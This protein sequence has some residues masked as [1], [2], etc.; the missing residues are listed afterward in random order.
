MNENEN[1]NYEKTHEK[2]AEKP[3]SKD[4]LKQEILIIRSEFK[5]KSSEYKNIQENILKSKEILSNLLSE[6]T[7]KKNL[8]LE[9]EKENEALLLKISKIRKN[10]LLSINKTINKKFYNHLKGILGDKKKERLLFHFFNFIFNLYNICKNHHFQNKEKNNFVNLG[11]DNDENHDIINLLRILKDENELKNLILYTTEIIKN[12]NTEEPNIYNK[13]KEMY[14]NLYNKIKNEEKPY[15]IDLL[16][17]Y[18]NN[19]FTIINYEKQVEDIKM[20]LNNL[21]NEKNA[22]FVKI[23]NLELLI[24]GYNVNKKIISNYI[25]I[26]DA[27]L[28]KINNSEKKTEENIDKLMKDIE[29]FKK[30]KIN[31]DNLNNNLELTKALPLGNDNTFYDKSSKKNDFKDNS[32]QFDYIT[33]SNEDCNKIEKI[34]LDEVKF[35]KEKNQNNFFEVGKENV[36]Y[37]KINKSFNINKREEKTRNL[38]INLKKS[39]NKTGNNIKCFNYKTINNNVSLNKK[40]I[41]NITTNDIKFKTNQKTFLEKD[42]FNKV[43]NNKTNN[44]NK[45]NWNKAHL[46]KKLKSQKIIKTKI[47]KENS[48]SIKENKSFLSLSNF[49]FSK[50]EKD[51]YIKPNNKNK[52]K[53][54][55]T[56]NTL[57]NKT[58]INTK[59]NG[60]KKIFH[61]KNVKKRNFSGNNIEKELFKNQTFLAK[62]EL[63]IE[64]NNIE[65]NINRQEIEEKNKQREQND[66]IENTKPNKEN[67]FIENNLDI[68]ELKD[69]I[70]DEMGSKKINNGNYLI[71]SNTNN[72]INK[73]GIQQNIVWSENLY[74]KINM[75]NSPNDIQLNIDK[76]IE[77]FTC[78]A[79]CT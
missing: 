17:D 3:N 58:Q 9:K 22:K 42:I 11:L 71:I 48:K 13:V 57:I 47:N 70:C 61:K 52:N 78:C 5:N 51:S 19:N 28:L 21:T 33:N 40:N 27:F 1:K 20:T 69:S 77:S 6:Y 43:K 49:I 29:N 54:N 55:I 24:K 31:Y 41:H 74:N 60:F 65:Y 44:K 37:E 79:S 63:K 38:G 4:I 16:Y 62:N 68:E 73:L 2:N 56:Y 26:L 8:I 75:K 53:K 59:Q 14:L 7:T 35:S 15:P 64:N 25:K 23:K 66:S 76:P 36:K 67:N 18:F 10:Q 30:I 12:L 45:E 46:I 32:K 50:N 34:N 72:Y 39:V